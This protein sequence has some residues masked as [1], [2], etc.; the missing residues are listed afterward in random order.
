M[1]R[2]VKGL[3]DDPT[4]PSPAEL[5]P[6]AEIT[7]PGWFAE[8]DP[9]QASIDVSGTVFARGEPYRCRLYVAPGQYP[10]NATTTDTPPG[11]FA[12]LSNG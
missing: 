7:S 5:P 11:D 9:M 1:N 6:E 4:A 3:I 10:N 2:A 8:I 12:P